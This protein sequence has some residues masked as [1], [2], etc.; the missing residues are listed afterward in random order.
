MPDRRDALCAA[1]DLVLTAEREAQMANTRSGGVDTVATV[2]K[3]DVF[4]GA[5]NAVPSRVKLMLDLRD[6]DATRREEVLQAVRAEAEA[7][8]ARRGVRIAEEAINADEPAVCDPEILTLLEG[9]CA[10]LGIQ[11][12]RLVSRAYHDTSFMARIAPVAMIFIPCKGGV[13]HR[14]DEYA[15]PEAISLGVRVLGESLARL[16]V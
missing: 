6:T 15:T 10:T 13:S 3:L 16:S 14:P 2:G 1:A 7:I 8:A 5:V 11:H 4:P 12:R 9:I